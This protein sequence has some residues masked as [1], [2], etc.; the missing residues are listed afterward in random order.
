MEYCIFIFWRESTAELCDVSKTRVHRIFTEK[1]S[2][3]R[4]QQ[5]GFNIMKGKFMLKLLQLLLSGGK[6]PN[7]SLNT[8]R[9]FLY[10]FHYFVKLTILWRQDLCFSG[11]HVICCLQLVQKEQSGYTKPLG[12]GCFLKT[13]ISSYYSNCLQLVKDWVKW[14]ERFF[15]FLCFLEKKK[16]KKFLLI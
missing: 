7:S 4:I 12:F 14:P 11:I 8:L 10:V 6:I 1:E 3:S 9:I 13:I 15:P 16:E 5:K 2:I